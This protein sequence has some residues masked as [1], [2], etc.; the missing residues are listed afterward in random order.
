MYEVG[1]GQGGTSER[2]ICEVGIG[3]TGLVQVG[4]KKDCLGKLSVREICSGKAGVGEIDRP[5]IVVADFASSD[6][7][8]YSLD[9]GRGGDVGVEIVGAR[10]CR[11]MASD[12][13][14]EEFHDGGVIS[15]GVTRQAFQG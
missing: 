12:E 9:I 8:E 1:S 2:R 15:V 11:C 5:R 10:T 13:R 6:C 14:G 3:E 7:G 4:I